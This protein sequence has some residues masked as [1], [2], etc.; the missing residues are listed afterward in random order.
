VIGAPKRQNGAVGRPTL[1]DD[2]LRHDLER[3]LAAGVPVAVAAQRFG[4]GSRTLH[5]WLA[6]GL[7][8]RELPAQP[9]VHDVVHYGADEVSLDDR[10]LRAEPG[11]VAEIIAASRRGSW[12]ASA[13]LLERIAPQRWA[14][15]A[16]RTE[17]PPAHV[18]REEAGIFAELDELARRRDRVS[19]RR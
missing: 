19:P 6:A 13:W 8:R 18:P 2:E 14:K 4:V 9:V 3:E 11:L 15:P 16:R 7:V 12:Q 5:R 1:L 17:E 10:L